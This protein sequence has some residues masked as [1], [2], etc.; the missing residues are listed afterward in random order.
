MEKENYDN[1]KDV[2]KVQNDIVLLT[3]KMNEYNIMLNEVSR[4]KDKTEKQIHINKTKNIK[5]ELKKELDKLI[6][7]Y[8]KVNRK[9]HNFGLSQKA[10]L[11][12]LKALKRIFA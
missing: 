5:I 6:I 11:L 3:S 1:K 7:D 10:R 12:Q 9:Y 4:I 2:L 8:E